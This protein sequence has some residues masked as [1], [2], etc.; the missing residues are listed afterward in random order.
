MPHLSEYGNAHYVALKLGDCCNCNARLI[1]APAYVRFA[2]RAS[3]PDTR[4][5]TVC[6]GCALGLGWVSPEQYTKDLKGV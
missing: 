1:N 3:L 6:P 2:F 4:L 5:I